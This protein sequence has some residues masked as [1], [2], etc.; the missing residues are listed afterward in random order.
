MTTL[1]S[2]R[3]YSVQQRLFHELFV[4]SWWVYAFVALVAII[5]AFS[6]HNAG[7]KQSHLQNSYLNLL[8]RKNELTKAQRRL[9]FQIDSLDDPKSVELILKKELGLVSR[10]QKKVYFSNP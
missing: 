10:G 2:Y 1:K 9:T 3:S 4:K 8:Q 6:I 7:Q 5:F